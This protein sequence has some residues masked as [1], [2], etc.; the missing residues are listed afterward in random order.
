MPAR[1]EK[2]M[3][4]MDIVN[5]TAIP[6]PWAEGDKIPWNEAGFSARMLGEHLSQDHDAAS[7]R[8]AIIDKQ[9]EWIFH[10]LLND[11]SARVLDLGCGPGLYTSRLAHC[12]CSCSGI[13][14]S[15]ASIAYAIEQA[16]REKLDCNYSEGDLRNIDFGTGF[17]LVLFIFGELNVFR[18][19]EARLILKKARAALE[20]GG[21]LVLE[22]HTFEAVKELGLAPVSWYSAKKGL[23]SEMP[24]FCLQ[25]NFWDESSCTATSRYYIVEA[26]SAVVT[27][28]AATAQAYTPKQYQDLLEEIGF[29][30]IQ[31]HPS[32][33]GRER[34]ETRAL[35]AIS[36][37]K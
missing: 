5:R 34:A 15:P 30:D 13:D 21:L 37:R 31:F 10:T 26:S 22:P 17:D 8:Y 23:F 11:H 20:S 27:R 16:R 7:R 14:F 25:E 29:K 24:H 32:M 3:D 6:A 12:G 33:E 4:L 35:M 9:V 18:P 1:K 2:D 28:Y 19:Q 36:A